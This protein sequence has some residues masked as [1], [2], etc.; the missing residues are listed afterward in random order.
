MNIKTERIG[1]G[2]GCHWC[3]EAVFQSLRGISKVE[4]GWIRSTPPHEKF[5]E[6]VIVTY[7]PNEMGLATLIEI[8]LLTH[9]STS[10]HK[11]RG[12]YR[13][14]VYTF[15]EQQTALAAD[16]LDGLQPAFGGELVTQVLRHEGFKPSNERFQNYYYE[17]PDRPFCKAYIDPKLRVL[18]GRFSDI[19]RSGEAP[20]PFSKM[21][22]CSNATSRSR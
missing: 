1:F 17:N 3:T 2:G 18:L 19:M 13:S 4:Q 10:S 11:M 12:K 15:N 6:A 20:V 16:I 14:A 8:H 9:S 7:Y 22:N 5:S 21:A